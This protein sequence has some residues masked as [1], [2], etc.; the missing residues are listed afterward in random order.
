LKHAGLNY[1]VPVNIYT[2][3]MPDDLALRYGRLMNEIQTVS[4]GA[5]FL[6]DAR[7]IQNIKDNMPAVRHTPCPSHTL[8]VDTH[9]LHQLR[10]R[11]R[12]SRS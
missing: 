6:D 5:N 12:R 1:E 8:S 9:I 3:D 4:K 2:E 11:I 7:F 10:G